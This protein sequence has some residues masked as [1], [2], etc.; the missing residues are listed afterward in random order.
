MALMTTLD[1]LAMCDLFAHRRVTTA[2][3]QLAVMR[4]RNAGTEH[5]AAARD[6]A[7]LVVDHVVPTCSSII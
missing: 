2:D 6:V 4:G 5:I 7:P 1:Q 3:Q